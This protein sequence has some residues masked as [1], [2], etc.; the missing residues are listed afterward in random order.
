MAI[1]PPVD[2]V[3]VRQM[4]DLLAL[5][6]QVLAYCR[7]E[8]PDAHDA[9]DA[10]QDTYLVVLQRIDVVTAH[11][12]PH[13]WL[14]ATARNACRGVVRRRDR[15]VTQPA[16]RSAIPGGSAH[17]GRDHE[18]P[19]GKRYQ[20]ELDRARDEALHDALDASEARER[21]AA[22]P[23]TLRDVAVLALEGRTAQEIAEELGISRNALDLRVHRIKRWF[24]KR[25][26]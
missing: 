14:F 21:V 9:Q 11:D 2:E 12:H 3:H 19:R 1:E 22:L 7:S 18:E 16:K 5:R 13:G 17:P 20:D 6:P 26:S 10:C 24:E 8:L 25:A 4:A 15:D 23:G